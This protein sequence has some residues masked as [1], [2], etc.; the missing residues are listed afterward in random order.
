MS[1]KTTGLKLPLKFEEAL[2]DLL[3]VKPPEKI[4][5]AK[6]PANMKKRPR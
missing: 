3:K 5:K 2:S 1:K 6:R 4:V